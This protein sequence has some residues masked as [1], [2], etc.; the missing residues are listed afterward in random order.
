MA[1]EAGR[2]RVATGRATCG[3]WEDMSNWARKDTGGELE[4]GCGWCVTEEGALRRKV[5]GGGAGADIENG[6]VFCGGL[7]AF[8]ECRGQEENGRGGRMFVGCCDNENGRFSIEKET[9][10]FSLSLAFF[11]SLGAFMGDALC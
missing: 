4:S 5:T 10:S 11:F 2:V 1:N 7:G 8:N 9:V 3:P 6:V